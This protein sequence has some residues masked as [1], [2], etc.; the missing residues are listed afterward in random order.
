MDHNKYLPSTSDS[1]IPLTKELQVFQKYI[2]HLTN[3]ITD[4]VRLSSELFK[5]K[6]I[7]N[8]THV[9]ANR[10][11][12]SKETTNYH[13]LNELMI[14]VSNDPSNLT[15]IISVLRDHYPHVSAIAENMITGK[16][17]IMLMLCTMIIIHI[18]F[19]TDYLSY[20]D[21]SRS[22]YRSTIAINNC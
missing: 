20:R 9:K 15:N 12:N 7:S 18:T 2:G 11:S 6:L 1:Y 14:A 17:T 22:V 3:A 10:E 16:T 19:L 21:V 4:P 13:L 5:A 8:S